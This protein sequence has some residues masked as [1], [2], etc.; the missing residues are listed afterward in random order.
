MEKGREASR[1]F[2]FLFIGD[3]LLTQM[4]TSDHQIIWGRRGTGKTHLLKAF[5][6]K[7][8][9]NPKIKSLAFYLS[10]DQL[11]FQT[12]VDIHFDS[13]V[14]KMKYFA[15]ETYKC[16]ILNLVELIIDEYENI[17]NNKFFY[18][19]QTNGEKKEYRFRVDNSLIKLYENCTYGLPLSTNVEETETVIQHSEKAKESM[20]GFNLES[21]I[22]FKEMML[23]WNPFLK[24]TRS[25]KS[26]LSN[27]DEKKVKYNYGFNIAK[28]RNL[29][30]AIVNA[31]QIDSLYLCLDELWLIDKKREISL[32]PLFLI[33]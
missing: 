14:E 22:S 17:I 30:K 32:Q 3:E 15:K 24:K 28:I 20:K 25:K 12:P 5:T 7:I 6:Q 10:C 13:D 2:T 11:N 27:S 18:L 19:N 4:E 31:L 16:F 29:I 33:I 8:N 1:G 21:K 26:V 9:T 23:N